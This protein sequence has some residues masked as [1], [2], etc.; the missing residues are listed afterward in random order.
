MLAEMALPEV[1]HIAINDASMVHLEEALELFAPDIEVLTLPA[2]DCQPYDRVSPNT[3][4]ISTRIDTLCRLASGNKPKKRILITTVNAV[5]QRVPPKEVLAKSVLMAKPG[6]TISRDHL[7][8][9]LTEHGYIR[10]PSATEPG[11]F[12]VRGSIIDIVISGMEEGVRLDFFGDTLESIRS[13]D[14]LTQISGSNAE[15]LALKPASEVPSHEAAIARFR[16]Q[17]RALFGA[18]SSDN[19]LYEAISEG[20]KYPGMEHWLPLFYEQLETVFD[21]LLG[22][23]VTLDHL[24]QESAAERFVSVLDHYN[25]RKEALDRKL[26]DGAPYHPV[27][28]ESLFVSLEEWQTAIDSHKTVQFTPFA[29]P[30]ANVVDAGYKAMLNLS[31]EATKTQTNAFEI[32]KTMMSQERLRTVIT[33]YTQGSLERLEGMLSGHDIHAVRL[34][35][36]SE[37]SKLSPKTVGLVVLGLEY[38]FQNAALRIITEQDLLGERV[39]RRPVRKR[40]AE[41]FLSEASSLTAGEVVVHKEHGIGRFEGL[42][43]LHVD[44]SYHDCLRLIYDGGDKLY[45]PVENIELITRYGSDS[46]D[47]RLDKLGGVAW[48]SRK[49]ALKKRITIAA[50]GLLKIAAERAVKVAPALVPMKGMYD[51]FCAKFPYAETEDQLRSIEDIQEDLQSGRPMDRLICGDVGFGKTEVALRAAFMAVANDQEGNIQVAV[52]AP[53]T[54]LSRQHYKTFKERFAGFPVRIRQLSRLVTAREAKETKDAL[55]NGSVDIV[56][57]THAVLAKSV[58]FKNL[59]LLIID[60]EQHFGVGQ[61][62]RLKELRSNI[63]VLTLSATPIP[64]TLQMSLTGIKELSLIATPP[65]DRLAVRTF[66][67]P[68]DGVVIRDA[69]LREHYRGGRSFYVCPRIKDLA[70]VEEKLKTLVPEIK[71]VVAHGQMPPAQL[72]DIMNAFYEGKYD[73]LLSTTIVESGLDVPSANTIIIHR[74]D[75]FGLSQLYQLR[76]RVGRGKTRAYAYLTLPPKRIPTKDAMKRLEVMQTLDSLGAGFSLASHDMD[77]RGFGNLVGEQQSGHIKEVGIELY[78][79]MLQEA[80]AA[81]REQKDDEVVI[82]DEW[83]PQINLGISVLIPEAYVPDLSLRMGLYRRIS[84]LET[85]EDVESFAAE[86]IDR[87][88]PIPE[89]VSHLLAIV[90]IKQL[91]RKAGVDKIDTGPKGTVISFRNNQF[92]NPGALLGYITQNAKHVKLRGDQ[93]LVIMREWITPESRINGVTFTLQAI[94]EMV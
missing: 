52:V 80:V 32:L 36:W 78:Q 26:D 27:P 37:V 92:S 49:A 34:D 88:G 93:K 40:K 14:P 66:V 43:T 77:I 4:I 62:E 69:L 12:A 29:Q 68:F 71:Y 83:A 45:V 58:N 31:A 73:L 11:E 25:A 90:K 67:M 39:I 79:H 21:M 63:H 18:V 84:T 46:E 94:V 59:G 38:G 13:F 42:E 64:R 76:G 57:G 20:R 2:W 89:E 3:G 9:Y 91:C 28:V 50:E 19:P 44:G 81:L 82:D 16:Q 65:V 30:G 41:N 56:V 60:E 86:L 61:K 54:L 70:D 23:V 5:L 87:F 75:Q 17:Y 47:V 7:I 55:A 24:L 8:E 1:I 53:T 72:D 51:E 48:Q 85:I 22:A 33:C 15:A 74:A 10:S 35:K 6:D